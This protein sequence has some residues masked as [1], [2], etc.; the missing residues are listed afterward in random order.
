MGQGR[1]IMFLLKR[2]FVLS[3]VKSFKNHISSRVNMARITKIEKL[4]GKKYESWKYNV[5]L[6]LMERGLWGLA[7]EGKEKPPAD[8]R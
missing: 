1:V 3:G 6:V 8:C 5:K 2:V 7:Q 4:S